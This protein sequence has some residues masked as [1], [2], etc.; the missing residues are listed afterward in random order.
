LIPR[1]HD[2]VDL[3]W[4]KVRFMC[5][6]QLFGFLTHPA[7]YCSASSYPNEMGPNIF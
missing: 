7:K 1:W 4:S 3:R 2:A 5:T 6:G